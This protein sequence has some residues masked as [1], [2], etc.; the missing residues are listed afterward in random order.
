MNIDFFKITRRT[1]SSCHSR[2]KYPQVLMLGY[3]NEEAYK[4]T[5]DEDKVTFY[6]R[7]KGRLWIKGETSGNFLNVESVALDCDNDTLLFKVNPVGPACH[8]GSTTCFGEPNAKGFC[9]L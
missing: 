3:M 7:S 4:K 1:S 8:T 9:I 2:R 6:S 5:V